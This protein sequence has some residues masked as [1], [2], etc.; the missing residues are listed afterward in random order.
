MTDSHSVTLEFNSPL[1]DLS[2]PVLVFNGWVEYAYSQS[3]FAAWQA[4]EEYREPT[5]EASGRNGEWVV[6][7]D[8]FGYPAGT[9]R[10][11]SVRLNKANLPKNARR[12]RIT[13]NMQVYWDKLEVVASIPCPKAKRHVAIL[14]RAMVS[15]VGFAERRILN[16]RRSI[17]DYASRPPFADARHPEGFYTEFGDAQELLLE[18]D[19]ALAIIGPGEEIHLGFAKLKP[20]RPPG[21]TR[22][23]VLEAN[24]WCKDCDLFTQNAGTV[25]PLPRRAEST[26]SPRSRRNSLHAKYNTRFESGY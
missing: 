11:G 17:Y 16:D 2:N 12:L 15:D 18:V 3:A 22:R 4:G 5:I 24:G 25:D 10:E 1:N 14:K 26:S 6:V 23:W 19:D 8:R 21:W 9:S 7:A 20:Q 13:T